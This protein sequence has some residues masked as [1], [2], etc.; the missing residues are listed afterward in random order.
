MLR[1]R[2]RVAMPVLVALILTAAS[3]SPVA[4]GVAYGSESCSAYKRVW[5]FSTARQWVYHQWYPTGGTDAVNW[6]NAVNT[7]REN[8]TFTT[9]TSWEV[10]W[11]VAK[12]SHGD[13]CYSI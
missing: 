8:N 11:D 13:G 1:R 5:I 3:A 9:A 10:H 12:V 4:A 2:S 7:Y 6:F